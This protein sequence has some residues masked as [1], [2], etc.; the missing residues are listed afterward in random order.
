MPEETIDKKEIVFKTE[1]GTI[2]FNEPAELQ[3]WIQGQRAL[4]SFHTP[5]S[6]RYGLQQ[7]FQQIDNGWNQLTKIISQG[8]QRHANNPDQYNSQVDQFVNLFN[9]LLSNKTIFTTDAPHSSFILRQ[10]KL[11][12]EYGV[13]AIAVLYDHN[14]LNIDSYGLAGIEQ[15]KNYIDGN[16]ER[17]EDE[18]TNLAELKLR[19]DEE[20]EA[21]QNEWVSKFSSE[22]DTAE[23]INSESVDVLA[24][25][26]KHI[27]SSLTELS[28]TKTAFKDQYTKAYESSRIELEQITATYDDK[29]ALQ[30]S[31]RYWGLQKKHHDTKTIQYGI[32]LAI[33]VVA[34]VV[35]LI[36]FSNSV[37]DTSFKDIHVSRLITAAVLTTFGIWLVKI[38]ANIF[39]SHMH[40]ATDSQERRTMIHTYLALTRK[41]QGPREEDRQ[42][43]LQTLFRPSTSGMV[44]DDAGPMHLVDMVNRLA[45]KNSS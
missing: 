7:V 35:G 32:A 21:H 1:S 26:K 40:L 42:L 29:L 34:V 27:E 24:K 18:S 31:V 44:K 25:W 30:A 43:I 5:V 38:L 28:D 3:S 6:Q 22:V 4:I 13:T 23:K 39:M 37:L 10:G 36:L 16:S 9:Q 8:L 17:I 41:G 20:L 14:I 15:V 45:S 19:W 2:R 33:S 12:P 11:R